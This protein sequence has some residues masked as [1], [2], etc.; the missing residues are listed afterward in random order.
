MYFMYLKYVFV[1]NTKATGNDS[2]TIGI[3]PKLL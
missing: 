3:G 1:Q 2:M